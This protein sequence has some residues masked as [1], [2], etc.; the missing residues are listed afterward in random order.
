MESLLRWNFGFS[1]NFALSFEQK[2]AQSIEM[3]VTWISGNVVVDSL[4][5]DCDKHLFRTISCDVN[6]LCLWAKQ[7]FV[8]EQNNIIIFFIFRACVKF[9]QFWKHEPFRILLDFYRLCGPAFIRTQLLVHA[10][11]SC[12]YV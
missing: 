10:Q 3:T 6:V 7:T 8:L 2:T 12:S 9:H 11:Y 4:I 1:I 5:H